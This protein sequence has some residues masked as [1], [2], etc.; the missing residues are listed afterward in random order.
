M[1]EKE[2]IKNLKL[3]KNV[4]PNK[5]FFEKSRFVILS[6]S[7]ITN[8]FSIFRSSSKELAVSLRS[9]LEVAWRGL[10]FSAVSLVVLFSIY[11]ASQELSPLFLPGLNYRKI[12]AEAE[13]VNAQIDIQLSQLKKFE[14]TSKQSG[15]ALQEVSSSKLNHLNS[16]ILNNELESIE[17]S[18]SGFG[19][20]NEANSEINSILKELSN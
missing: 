10:A 6:S 14:D 5:D 3:L 7:P 17:A 16:S 12:A 18:T 13:S 1:E 9:A 19:L 2:I 4:E 20:D 8:R 11:Y 15:E